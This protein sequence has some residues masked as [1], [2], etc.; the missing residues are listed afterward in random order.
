MTDDKSINQSITTSS[1][2]YS[3]SNFIFVKIHG[4]DM[5]MCEAPDK[6]TERREE[7]RRSFL[8]L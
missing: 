3:E 8:S 1:D 2:E 7:E 6:R 5:H 4:F